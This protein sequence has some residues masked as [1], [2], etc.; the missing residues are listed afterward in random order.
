LPQ[1]LH[2]SARENVPGKFMRSIVQ[3]IAA[4]CAALF[5][6]SAAAPERIEYTLTPILENGALTA[7]QYDLRFRGDPDGEGSLRLPDSWGGQS[8]LWKGISGLEIVS[9]AAMRDGETPNQRLLSHR[10]NARIHVRYRV[11]QDWDGVPRAELGNSYRPVIQ[12][13]YFHLIGEAS[14]VTPGEADIAAPIR[15]RV[16]NMPRGWAFASDLEHDGLKLSDLW[17]SVTVGGDFRV[18]RDPTT[19]VRLAIRGQWTFAD[20]D[21]MRQASTIIGGHRAF[22]SD[23][24][25]PYLVTVLQLDGPEGWISVG[26]TG[27][28]DAFAFFSTPNGQAATITRTLAHESLHTWVPA[29]IGGMPQPE[30]VDYWLSEGFTDFYTGRMLVREGVWTPQQYASDLNDML[31]AYAQSSVRTE[32]NTRVAADFWNNQD[33]QKLPYQRGRMLA[34][35]WDGRLRANGRSFD[36]IVRDMRV[37]ARAADGP[38]TAVGLFRAASSNAGL[39]ASPELTS[40]IEA[41]EPILLGADLLAPCGQFV[42]RQVANFHRG[43]DIEATQANNNIIAGV[44]PSL[45]AYAAGVRNGMTLVRRDAGEIGDS[46]QEIAYVMR[47]GETERTFRYM[48]RGHGAFTLQELTLADN[49]AGDR[50]AQCISVIGGA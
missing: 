17:S 42:T 8:E 1:S 11:I 4:G 48:P 21:F 46:E 16:R 31:R 22:W 19:N 35:V 30:A 50:L 45:P 43:F 34:M 23:A 9:G 24:A 18:L 27:L 37:R 26:G 25:S 6:A 41:G 7:L 49:L 47:D 14:M 2:L 5:C 44:D 15:F 33:A 28:D 12:A 32:P 29:Q 36:E 20:A 39:D 13:G 10:P 38:V 40:N 3:A